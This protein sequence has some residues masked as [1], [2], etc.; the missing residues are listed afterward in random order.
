MTNLAPGF[1]KHP[2]YEVNISPL[3]TELVVKVGSAI[4]ARSSQAVE[5]VESK[6][7]L[8][9]YLPM[10]DVDSKLISPTQTDTYCPFKG[11]AS[12]WSLDVAGQH[13]DD[14]LWAYMTPY[15][16]CE[17]LTGYASFYT[18]KVDLYIDGE[19]MNKEG[20]GW[21]TQGNNNA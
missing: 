11:H 7:R 17:S 18:N 8:V 6:H 20:P 15:D 21:A 5:V 3:S 12:Y 14:A 4:I 1:T 16:E 2:N 9:W 10:D 19:L 13:I